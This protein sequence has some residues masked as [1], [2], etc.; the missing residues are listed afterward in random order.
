[1]NWAA[2]ILIVWAAF[3]AGTLIFPFFFFSDGAMFLAGFSLVLCP[4]PAAILLFF[5]E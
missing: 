4:I 2:K 1:M 3:T 5:V